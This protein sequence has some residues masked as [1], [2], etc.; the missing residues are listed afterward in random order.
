MT[1]NIKTVAFNGVLLALSFGFSL[2]TANVARADSVLETRST[3]VS[4][5]GL[6]LS[7]PAGVGVAQER[8]RQAARTVCSRVESVYDLAPHFEFMKCVDRAERAAFQQIKGAIVVAS[9]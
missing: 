9:K 5:A 8:V 7:T 3:T 6:N 4:L 2:A 1:M